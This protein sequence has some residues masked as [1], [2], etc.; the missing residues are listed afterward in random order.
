MPPIKIKR[1]F[2]FE[3]PF[4]DT[5]NKDTTNGNKNKTIKPSYLNC[6][7]MLENAAIILE[8]SI[9]EPCISNETK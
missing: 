9:D 5:R 7:K 3:I 2:A 4:L 1:V 8:K 6:V